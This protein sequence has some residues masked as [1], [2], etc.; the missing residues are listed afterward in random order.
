M[1]IYLLFFIYAKVHIKI[2]HRRFGEPNIVETLIKYQRRQN[3]KSKTGLYILDQIVGIVNLPFVASICSRVG[4]S[5]V[6]TSESALRMS[7]R[8]FRRPV[9]PVSRNSFG[10]SSW[11]LLPSCIIA[12]ILST[13]KSIGKD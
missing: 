11:L 13:G 10:T 4:K 1:C 2:P 7:G 12:I 5:A 6:V 3:R 9:R 8:A